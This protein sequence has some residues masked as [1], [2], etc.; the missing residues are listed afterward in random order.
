MPT[1][2]PIESPRPTVTVLGLPFFRGNL[3]DSV[4]A[5]LTGGLTVA[6]SAP[7]L[8]DMVA[9]HPNREA[10][11]RA[12]T[13]LPDSGLMVLLWNLL[14][15][16]KLERLSG[17]KFMQHLLRRE[18]VREPGASFWIMPSE[19]ARQRNLEWLNQQGF[20]LTEE[21]CFV[22]PIYPAGPITDPEL[23][24]R[25][26]E[27]APKHIVIC[28]GGG[29]QERLGLYLLRNLPYRPSL[30]CLGAAIAFLTGVQTNI[31]PWADRLFLG[32]L[33]RCLSQPSSFVP[34]YLRALRL[35]P[36]MLR[37]GRKMPAH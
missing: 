32:W 2:E 36:L 7:V 3:E 26:R 33:F 21:D 22:P 18:A 23:L 12:S 6:P 20:Q 35:I 28:V 29:T 11:T 37:F 1:S 19:A 14:H 24:E 16:D 25:L 4:S 15:R 34:R 31:P 8:V 30:Y 10:L 17:L 9:N 5:A 27:R 13:V